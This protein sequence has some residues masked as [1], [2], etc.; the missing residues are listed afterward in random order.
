LKKFGVILLLAIFLF[1]SA[2]YYVVF[3]TQQVEIRDEMRAEINIGNF[4]KSFTSVISINRTDLSKEVE[5]FDDQTEMRYHGVMYDIAKKTET[6][7]EVTFYCLNDSKESSLYALL[8]DHVNTHIAAKPC[9]DNSSKKIS[10]N[11]VK[12]Y[13]TTDNSFHFFPVVNIA[14]LT[15]VVNGYL[16]AEKQKSTPPPPEFC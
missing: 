14:D 10:D 6:D 4:D 13:F 16:P 12:I 5:F 1:N 11:V 15:P 7:N 2:G 8:D 3:L 9:K